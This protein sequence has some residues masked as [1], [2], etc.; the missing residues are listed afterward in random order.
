MISLN[1]RDLNKSL[2]ENGK[3]VTNHTQT[4]PSA[5]QSL[6]HKQNRT[7]N[8]MLCAA[9]PSMKVKTAV[10]VSVNKYLRKNLVLLLAAPLLPSKTS[11]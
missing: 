6:H 11:C 5:A 8:A 2:S 10:S 7:R 1:Y 9:V 4:A 3:T